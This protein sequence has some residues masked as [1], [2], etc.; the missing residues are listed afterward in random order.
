MRHDTGVF[1]CLHGRPSAART[2]EAERLAWESWAARDGDERDARRN[3]PC[4][5][6][7]LRDQL[8][9]LA[10]TP[11]VSRRKRRRRSKKKKKKNCHGERRPQLQGPPTVVPVQQPCLCNPM[12]MQRKW[13]QWCSRD[14]HPPPFN[15][16]ILQEIRPLGGRV[17]YI[18]RV[19]S[20]HLEKEAG[21]IFFLGKK[22]QRE[23]LSPPPPVGDQERWGQ[24]SRA[25][26][27]RSKGSCYCM[28]S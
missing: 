9:F 15:H 8:F 27:E 24:N 2:A 1:V 28:K 10:H 17:V 3:N 18:F 16:H 21:R 4:S 6:K 7:G 23:S 20:K 11:D 19:H 14:A 25:A 5:L 12:F 22:Q 13:T 26:L